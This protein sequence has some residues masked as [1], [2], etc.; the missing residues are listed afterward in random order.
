VNTAGA[1]DPAKA[2]ELAA[3]N[4]VRLYTIGIGADS[5]RVNDFFG[6]RLINPS[7]DLDEKLLRGIAEQTGG[8][9]FRA[10]DTRELAGI[11]TEIDRLEPA[12]EQ[13]GK[14]RPVE[15]WFH[16][17]LA[18][19]FVLAFGLALPRTA[20]WSLRERIA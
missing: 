15:E 5:L 4:Q 20:L 17:P 8:R 13:G 6:S 1:L 11:Y 3:A 10:R 18:L 16:L 14:Y 9:Y 12:M 7:A 19:A 2:A